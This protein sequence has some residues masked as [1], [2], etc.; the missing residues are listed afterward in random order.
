MSFKEKY[1]KYKNKYLALKKLEQ[2]GS[3]DHDDGEWTKVE[4]KKKNLGRGG[5]GRGGRGRGGRGR[6]GHGRGGHDRGGPGRDDSGRG[7]LVG[8]DSARGNK[9]V[10][11]GKSDVGRGDVKKT[12]VQSYKRDSKSVSGH[13]REIKVSNRWSY[14]PDN[15]SVSDKKS[16]PRLGLRQVSISQDADTPYVIFLKSFQDIFKNEDANVCYDSKGFNFIGK[17]YSGLQQKKIY[18]SNDIMFIRG[19]EKKYKFKIDRINWSDSGIYI[20]LKGMLEEEEIK[21]DDNVKLS[22]HSSRELNN[23]NRIHI[24]L[25]NNSTTEGVL[26]PCQLYYD[27]VSNKLQLKLFEEEH[28][29][30]FF[31][32]LYLDNPIFKNNLIILFNKIFEDLQNFSEKR[33]RIGPFNPKPFN[34]NNFTLDSV[35]EVS[36]RR[37]SFKSSDNDSG[38]GGRGRGNEGFAYG[39]DDSGR[40]VNG[41]SNNT[42]WRKSS[43][44]DSGKGGRGRGN[45][46]FAYGRDDSGRG[47]SRRSNNPN[48]RKQSEK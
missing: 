30:R 46:G 24:I 4:S 47:V 22:L 48:W 31:N 15:P 44:N 41:S 33:N 34:P 27:T 45:E 16:P 1:L 3:S 12:F 25:E 37:I 26:I 5:H 14:N 39:R 40:G 10:D 28:E 21:F 36:D 29:R 20:N 7:G 9:G 19:L 32:D 18:E 13:Q 43:D 8:D 2:I 6:G 23:R 38:K 17:I 11:Y 42:N 35:T